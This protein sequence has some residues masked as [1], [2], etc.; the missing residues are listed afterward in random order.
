MDCHDRGVFLWHVSVD[1]H[2]D[3]RVVVFQPHQL[4]AP[5]LARAIVPAVDIRC[6][7][8]VDSCDVFGEDG[9]AGAEFDC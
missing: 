1:G 6:E 3:C 2:R 9:G 7:A 4:V 8:H 5:E